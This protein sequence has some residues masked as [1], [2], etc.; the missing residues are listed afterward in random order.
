MKV[1]AGVLL[2]PE[3]EDECKMLKSKVRRFVNSYEVRAIRHIRVGVEKFAEVEYNK[4]IYYVPLNYEISK[5]ISY[6]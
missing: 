1:V 2:Y 4:Q 3:S 5:I 6:R